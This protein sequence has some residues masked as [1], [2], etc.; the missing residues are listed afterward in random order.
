MTEAT[1][2]NAPQY[3][4]DYSQAAAAVADVIA[5]RDRTHGDPELFG[6][7]FAAMLNA[8][9]IPAFSRAGQLGPADSFV[10]LDLMKS[11]RIA[12]G[13]PHPAHFTDKAGYGLLG[14]VHTSRAFAMLKAHQDAQNGPVPGPEEADDTDAAEVA[15]Q[16]FVD[17]TAAPMA[18]QDARPA[19][20]P[21]AEAFAALVRDAA[22]SPE[23]PEEEES[24][25]DG[26]PRNWLRPA[27][28]EADRD[29][30]DDIDLLRWSLDPNG[31]PF[32]D[33]LMMTPG[34]VTMP[35]PGVTREQIMARQGRVLD[36]LRTHVDTTDEG[37]NAVKTAL[38]RYSQIGKLAA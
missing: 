23:L 15:R 34:G 5:D 31:N 27:V 13:G 16:A 19:R 20:K 18:P 26:G 2:D 6:A 10:I 14:L 37:A 33:L 28:S 12:C 21:A 1:P 30:V 35:R 22:S 29:P 9:L 7:T 38:N 17:A 32:A 4:D 8:Y 36:I 24:A 3:M 25:E 11:A